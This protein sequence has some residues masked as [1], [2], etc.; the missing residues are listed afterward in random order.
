MLEPELRSGL[1]IGTYARGVVI[2]CAGD[3]TGPKGI[4]QRR[5]RAR[6]GINTDCSLSRLNALVSARHLFVVEPPFYMGKV[7]IFG[8]QESFGHRFPRPR[9]TFIAPGKVIQL[10]EITW[11]ALVQEIFMKAA[12]PKSLRTTCF[13]HGE[14]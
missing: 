12:G 11:S 13:Q 1:G 2:R 6:C 4:E 7:M 5:P 9:W 3:E 14:Q 10:W 8:Y